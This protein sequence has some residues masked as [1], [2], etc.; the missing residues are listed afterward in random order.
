MKK[1]KFIPLLSCLLILTSCS[2]NVY[3]STSSI[4]SSTSTST[5]TSEPEITDD[6]LYE[7][8]SDDDTESVALTKVL[9]KEIVEL[10]IPE[11]INGREVF[12]VRENAI[13][14]LPNLRK[15]VIP[16]NI[17]SF[18]VLNLQNCPNLE[19]IEVSEDNPRYVVENNCLL[20]KEK[21]TLVKGI[22]TSIIPDTVTSINYYAF[23]YCDIKSVKLPKGV[24]SYGNYFDHCYQ[25]NDFQI[26]PEN[27][28]FFSPAGSNCWM[29]TKK[30]E[31]GKLCTF[32]YDIFKDG[33]IPESDTEIKVDN[34]G[35][36]YG[37]VEEL[38]IPKNL[39]TDNS[40]TMN[41]TVDT[42]FGSLYNVKKLTVS[43]ENPYFSTVEG[44]GCLL[45][46]KNSITNYEVYKLLYKNIVIPEG[47][48]RIT[49][50]GNGRSNY[51]SRML[52]HVETIHF[53]KTMQY[54]NVQE[55]LN[56]STLKEMTIA[57]GNENLFIKNNCLVRK[58]DNGNNLLLAANNASIPE[59]AT[60]IYS[61]AFSGTD[62]EKIYIPKNFYYGGNIAACFE[63]CNNLKSIEVDPDNKYFRASNNCLYFKSENAVVMLV[64]DAS[65]EEGIEKFG[66]YS[67]SYTRAGSTGLTSLKIPSTLKSI[68]YQAFK[69]NYHS[70]LISYNTEENRSK[71]PSI[72]DLSNTNIEVIGDS[73]LYGNYNLKKILLPST[74]TAIKGFAFGSTNI[75]SLEIPDSVK[76]IDSYF[77]TGCYSLRKIVVPNL[78]TI[79]ANMFTGA[80]NL[81]DVTFKMTLPRFKKLIT[82][83]SGDNYL[84]TLLK[85]CT[86][87]KTIKFLEYEG[88][89]RYIEVDVDKIF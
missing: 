56:K 89:S 86:L 33:H 57:E 79:N 32:I 72:F 15:L 30:D 41:G 7:Y 4:S 19:T 63:N 68:I 85:S 81:T 83:S 78:D 46:R 28:K 1:T 50:K 42:S 14:D 3:N 20:N 48:T 39:N 24:T 76:Q 74:L 71:F 55:G 35:M 47:V 65:I 10:V 64:G 87:L 25:L 22:K 69:T 23:S 18:N 26:D 75:F 60:Y 16:K 2:K 80:Y 6:D 61:Y 11:T 62:I 21:T 54:V 88:S 67:Y 13:K 49:N 27:T 38:Y 31:D 73:S 59:E 52:E 37:N 29:G 9:D 77:V 36:C 51:W 43:S 5:S 58:V 34:N 66:N 44:S 40:G 17:V 53:P 70:G 82:S 45:Y 12:Y 84:N 8:I